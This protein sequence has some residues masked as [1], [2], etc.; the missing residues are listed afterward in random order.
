MLMALK[1]LGSLADKR[2]K[3]KIK[4]EVIKE[5]FAGD[6]IREAIVIHFFCLQSESEKAYI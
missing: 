2:K 4:K 1:V 6:V 3:I 5:G